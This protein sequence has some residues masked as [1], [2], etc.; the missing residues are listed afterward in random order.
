MKDSISLPAAPHSSA[1]IPSAGRCS[2]SVTAAA[3]YPGQCVMLPTMPGGHNG[4]RRGPE[5]IATSWTP[6]A[7]SARRAQARPARKSR[8]RFSTALRMIADSSGK[9][10]TS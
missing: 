4:S 2:R 7:A 1:S 9:S 3:T 10:E 6:S 8:R 5:G